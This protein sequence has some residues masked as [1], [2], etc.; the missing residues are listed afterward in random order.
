MLLRLL[1]L[2]LVQL[3]LLLLLL[4]LGALWER[5]PHM[6]PHELLLAVLHRIATAAT[7]TRGVR[8]VGV[9]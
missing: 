7:K 5:F 8:K 2:L 3:L 1:L 4:P 6:K 9:V